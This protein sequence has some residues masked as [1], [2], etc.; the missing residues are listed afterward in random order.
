MSN[1]PPGIKGA[2][3]RV[4][5]AAPVAS[6]VP[7]VPGVKGSPDTAPGPVPVDDLLE[8]HG[9]RPETL[10]ARCRHSPRS[11]PPG[12]AVIHVGPTRRERRPPAGRAG[13]SFAFFSADGKSFRP[14][15]L[16]ALP[17]R[18]TQVQV[19]ADGESFAIAATTETG[20]SSAGQERVWQ[21]TDGATWTPTATPP[22]DQAYP[23]AVGFLAGR[24]TMVS[25]VHRQRADIGH[26][27]QRRLV[28]GS[29]LAPL[30]GP[31]PPGFLTQALS[32]AIGPFGVAIV[33]TQ[34]NDP[35]SG[36]GP[37]QGCGCPAQAE[38]PGQSG[39]CNVVK[40][41]PQHLGRRQREPGA[42]HGGY[43]QPIRR[44]CP[45]RAS[46]YLQGGARDGPGRY[47]PLTTP[48]RG[49]GIVASRGTERV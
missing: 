27:R 33:A 29:S 14:V 46:R 48:P 49:G 15:T 31:M 16:P 3:G 47:G 17:G 19:V 32:A 39:R 28:R 26:I 12:G 7:G 40:S 38:S 10:R 35:Q 37:R 11:Q 20:I 23:S 24:L 34:V 45:V 21:S 1:T 8:H 25:G 22:A 43:R 13:Q 36:R 2:A 5:P 42:Q 4:S 41:G 18:M 44:H 30:A 9:N 6:G